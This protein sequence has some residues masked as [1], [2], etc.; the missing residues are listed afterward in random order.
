MVHT[1]E[2]WRAAKMTAAQGA[3]LSH[4][5]LVEDCVLRDVNAFL[6]ALL[7]RRAE[8]GDCPISVRLSESL[9]DSI[10]LFFDQMRYAYMHPRS[11]SA[12]YLFAREA[13]SLLTPSRNNPKP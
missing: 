9:C 8:I 11:D 10:L 7:V 3:T 6:K 1:F 12:R 4:Y 13:P 5:H 2:T